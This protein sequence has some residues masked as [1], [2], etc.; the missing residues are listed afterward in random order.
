MLQQVHSIE[1]LRFGRGGGDPKMSDIDLVTD[2]FL[3][4]VPKIPL[5][6]EFRLL[7]RDFRRLATIS[8]GL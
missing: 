2:T 7:F 3:L 1:G 6:V 5:R 4:K 8:V